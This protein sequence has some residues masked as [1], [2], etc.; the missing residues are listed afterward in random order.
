KLK[1]LKILVDRDDE[2]YLLQIFTKPI[3]DR[4]TLFIEIIQRKGS[5]GFGEGNFKA[6]FES[7]EREQE[8][9]GN[10]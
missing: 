5:R 1:E 4:P 9:R 3:V 8:R 7:I 6:L 10:L 2:G